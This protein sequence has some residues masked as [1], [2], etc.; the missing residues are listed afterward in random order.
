MYVTNEIRMYGLLN[1]KNAYNSNLF[2]C[3]LSNE[4]LQKL[5]FLE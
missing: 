5:Q 3:A 1:N 2:K 4:R